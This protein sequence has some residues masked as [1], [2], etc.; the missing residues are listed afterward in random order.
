[1]KTS[2]PA[3]YVFFC[4][5]ILLS[6]VSVAT[7]VGAQCA[8]YRSHQEGIDLPTPQLHHLS[9]QVFTKYKKIRA[10]TLRNT[11]G[12]SIQLCEGYNLPEG[13]RVEVSANQS[14]CVL[15]GVPTQAQAF[16]PGFVVATNLQG[17]SLAKAN[18][19][20][21]ALVLVE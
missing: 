13:L 19:L 15:R 4:L 2:S 21:N 20:V 9:D 5:L 16:T 18:I 10:I 3:L 11:G 7:W 12:K 17:S 8:E 14:T 1:M 6:S